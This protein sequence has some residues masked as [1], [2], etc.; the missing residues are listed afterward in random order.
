MHDEVTPDRRSS[1]QWH[2]GRITG[3]SSGW[4]LTRYS[5]TTRKGI[6]TSLEDHNIS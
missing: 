2:D 1:S 5:E 6:E 3:R 4:D